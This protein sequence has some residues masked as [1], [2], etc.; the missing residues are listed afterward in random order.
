MDNTIDPKL[1]SESYL[2]WMEVKSLDSWNWYL[3]S[4][5]LKKHKIELDLSLNPG[6]ERVNAWINSIETIL[7][8]K[9][10]NTK[11]ATASKLQSSAL[12]LSKKEQDIEFY[13]RTILSDPSN[14]MAHVSLGTAYKDNDQTE[15]AIYEYEKAIIINPNDPLAYIGL[16]TLYFRLSAGHANSELNKGIYQYKKAIEL[17]PQNPSFLYSLG[18]M[19]D[20][21]N[22]GSNAIISTIKAQKL[23]LAKQDKKGIADCRRNL[24]EYFKKYKYKPEDFESIEIETAPQSQ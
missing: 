19:Y 1:G 17:D 10:T 20:L 18:T 6:S 3:K 24:R 11:V 16:G 22:E 15:K 8:T 4:G 2:I 7:E 12:P 9:A 13:K 5:N 14:Y 21:N 23:F